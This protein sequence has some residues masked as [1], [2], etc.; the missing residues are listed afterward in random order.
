MSLIGLMSLISPI[1]D[2]PRDFSRMLENVAACKINHGI[3]VYGMCMYRSAKTGKIYYFGDSKSGD[4]EQWELFD[5]GG[6][7]DAKKVRNSASA[8]AAGLIWSRLSFIAWRSWTSNSIKYIQHIL[9]VRI[10]LHLPEDVRYA[11]FFIT[12]ERAAQD[13]HTLSAIHILFAP[14]AVFFH[15]RMIGDREQRERQRIF[16]SELLM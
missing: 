14:R 7:V 1:H 16:F 6:K 3:G 13:S 4:V 9:T 5:S 12:D 15:H 8:T 11:A 10:G 2:A